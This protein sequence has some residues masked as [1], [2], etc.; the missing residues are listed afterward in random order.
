M[1]LCLFLD[2]HNRRRLKQRMGAIGR[3][4]SVP[5]NGACD[6]SQGENSM[7]YSIAS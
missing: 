2:R 4:S 7:G 3:P 6:K 1:G 5:S